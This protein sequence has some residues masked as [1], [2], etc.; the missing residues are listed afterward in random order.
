[1]IQVKKNQKCLYQSLKDKISTCQSLSSIK[2]EEYDRGSKKIWIVQVFA[3]LDLPIKA[4][5]K[6][7]E[8][9]IVLNK[10]EIKAGILKSEQRF[11][12]SSI[13]PSAEQAAKGIRGH[14]GI[15]NKVHRAKDVF[16][17]QDHNKIKHIQAAVNVSIFNTLSIQF[18]SQEVD[19]SISY[20][21]VF[22][23]Q[24]FKNLKWNFRT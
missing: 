20:A 9:F 2:E 24:N 21:Q 13:V 14:W 5:W 3:A 22:F 4:E 12:I 6:G 15:E 8:S 10:S 16:F 7:L 18:L 19:N 17:N 1:M 23:A 11:Y